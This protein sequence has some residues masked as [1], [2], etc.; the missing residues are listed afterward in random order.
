M[1]RARVL[2]SLRNGVALFVL[3]FIMLVASVFVVLYSEK[4]SGFA[5]QRIVG[6]LPVALTVERTSGSIADGLTLYD[7][8]FENDAVDVRIGQLEVL[9]SLLPLLGANVNVERVAT[10]DMRI[11]PKPST[12][13]SEPTP[14]TVPTLRAPVTINVEVLSATNTVIVTDSE[15][16]IQDI[17]GAI[18]WNDTRLDITKLSVQAA[19]WSVDASG[20]ATLDDTVPV[21]LQINWRAPA[22]KVSGNGTLGGTLDALEVS[23]T[24]D[25]AFSLVSKGVVKAYDRIIPLVTMTHTCESECG[26]PDVTLRDL[27]L[28]HDGPI[29]DSTVSLAVNVAHDRLPATDIELRGKSSFEALQIESLTAKASALDVSANG[30]VQWAPEPN[31]DL[32]ANISKLDTAL[33]HPS[34]VGQISGQATVLGGSVDAFAVALDDLKG[35]IN[36]YAL[37]AKADIERRGD[38]FTLQPFEVRIGNN[39]ILASGNVRGTQLDLQIEATLPKLD[40]IVPELRGAFN[41]NGFLKGSFKQPVAE[42]KLDASDL[43]YNELSVK[44][45][46]GDVRVTQDGSVDGKLEIEQTRSG[47]RDLGNGELRLGGTLTTVDADIDW[48]LPEAQISTSLQASP[49]D[50]GARIAIRSASANSETIGEWSLNDAFD[51]DIVDGTV[52]VAANRWSNAAAFIQVDELRAESGNIVVNAQLSE[53]PLQTFDPFLP[54]GIRLAGEVNANVALTSQNGHWQGNVD[55]IQDDTQVSVEDGSRSRRLALQVFKLRTVIS[56]DTADCEITVAGDHDLDLRGE[57]ELSDLTNDAGP[58]IKGSLDV[59]LPDMAWLSP[60]VDGISELAGSVA[61]NLKA[62]GQSSAPTLQGKFLLKD[63]AVS[64]EDAGLRLEDLQ[65]SGE[66]RQDGALT[67]QGSAHSGGGDLTFDGQV[68]RAWTSDRSLKM[69]IKG[70]DVQAFNARDYQVWVSPDMTLD[71]DAKGARVA[72]RID[73]PRANIRVAEVPPD[74]VRA[75]QDIKVAGRQ[76]KEAF[77]LPVEGSVTLALGDKV[78]LFAL[79]LDADLRGDLKLALVKAKAPQFNGRLYLENGKFDAYGQKLTVDRGNVFYAGVIDNPTLDFRATRSIANTGES[80]VAGVRVTGPAQ[81]PSIEIFT[82]PAVSQTD[83]LSYLLL[84]RAANDTS[85]ADGAALSRA[86]LA[87]G[88]SRSSG[89]TSQLAAGLGLDELGVGGDSVDATELVAGKQVSDR[90]YIKYTFG[91]FSNLGALLLRYQLSRHIALEA[92][93]DE[94][95]SLDILYTIEK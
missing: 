28:E 67:L 85:E 63:G 14:L 16:V 11:E 59:A 58:T 91:V 66:G 30:K 93:S 39:E 6:W 21:Q 34:A 12:E 17:G 35:Q 53:M 55:W 72:G 9:V 5:V 36:G 22:Q 31:V 24:L 82:E 15:F 54:A 95:Q 32:R 44:A 89:L 92:G 48:S 64:L 88:T 2:R 1:T 40:Q 57:V 20:E 76:P 60:W 27:F 65:L 74:V 81:N 49:T 19:D 73:V 18:G 83:A 70:S 3:L 61:L 41:A 43:I 94:S 8:H 80:I 69:A 47:E 50:N 37:A 42:F 7:L 86:A 90:L 10:T 68:A 46:D 4:A 23:H 25:G 29:N 33:I 38:Q 77:S 87:I 13:P 78:H 51:V 71:V 45:I 79:G 75:S 52:T 62:S 84:G 56:G 26:V